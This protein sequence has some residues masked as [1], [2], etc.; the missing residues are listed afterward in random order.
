[1]RLMRYLLVS[2]CSPPLFKYKTAEA[3]VSEGR[4]DDVLSY[5]MSLQTGTAG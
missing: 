5:V 2:Q 3:L 1:M 4:A